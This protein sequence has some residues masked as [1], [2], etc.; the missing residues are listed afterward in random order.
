MVALSISDLD[1]ATQFW[2]MTF[3]IHKCSYTPKWKSVAYFFL[4]FFKFSCSPAQTD[5]WTEC[6]SNYPF[7]LHY[8]GPKKKKKTTDD[9]EEISWQLKT[10][11]FKSLSRAAGQ[12]DTGYFVKAIKNLCNQRAKHTFTRD[13]H[14]STYQ[15]PPPPPH[16]PG[17]KLQ[18]AHN[19]AWCLCSDAAIKSVDEDCGTVATTWKKQELNAT[20]TQPPKSKSWINSDGQ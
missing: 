18:S 10:L 5:E 2:M 12:L 4:L 13:S 8:G 19:E 7:L 9:Q 3:L 6:N 16:P 20:H 11:N 17:G 15:Y 14:S 1:L